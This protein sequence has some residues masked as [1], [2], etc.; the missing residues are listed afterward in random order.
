ME[1][2]RTPAGRAAGPCADYS[3]QVGLLGILPGAPL[4]S[5]ETGLGQN[6]GLSGPEN[7]PFGARKQVGRPGWEGTP[8]EGY[9][10]GCLQCFMP[11]ELRE[12]DLC[13]STVFPGSSKSSNTGFSMMSVASGRSVGE[14]ESMCRTIMYS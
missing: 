11:E 9:L 2:Q 14:G 6:G 13:L 10:L 12:R 3:G 8:T 4:R 1:G 7:T 5:P